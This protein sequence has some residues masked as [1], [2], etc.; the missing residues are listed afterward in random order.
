MLAIWLGHALHRK[1]RLF[2]VDCFD[3]A[4]RLADSVNH[5]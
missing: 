5:L 4:D 3:A 1:G 2:L